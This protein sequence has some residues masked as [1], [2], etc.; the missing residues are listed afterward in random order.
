MAFG[1]GS[2]S[3]Q[4]KGTLLFKI[5]HPNSKHTSY[6]FGTHHAFGKSFFDSLTTANQ[7]L[8]SS[9]MLIKENLNLPPVQPITPK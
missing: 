8:A 3:P 1:M 2:N 6:L 5:T 9:T 7:A 4:S